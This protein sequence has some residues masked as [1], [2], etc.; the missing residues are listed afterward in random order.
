MKKSESS[1][2]KLIKSKFRAELNQD[3]IL[4]YLRYSKDIP[5]NATNVK[6]VFNVPSGGNWSGMCLDVTSEDPV[7]VTWEVVTEDATGF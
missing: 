1:K 3:D 5:N 7:V 6:V 2:A 4:G